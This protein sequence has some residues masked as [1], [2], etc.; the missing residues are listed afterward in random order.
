MTDK[1]TGEQRKVSTTGV[2]AVVNGQAEFKE[3]KTM[4]EGSQFYVVQP[5]DTGR[6]VLRAGEQVVVRASDLYD[7]KVLQE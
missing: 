1:K 5:L 4:A 7:G 3:V 2:Y 6:R